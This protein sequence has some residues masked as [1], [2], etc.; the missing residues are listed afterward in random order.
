MVDASAA[1]NPAGERPALCRVPHRLAA[2]WHG[3]G[4]VA[5]S[6]MLDHPLASLREWIGPTT[7]GGGGCWSGGPSSFPGFSLRPQRRTRHRRSPRP[8]GCPGRRTVSPC[9]WAPFC[10]AS[11]RQVGPGWCSLG[12]GWCVGRPTWA[13]GFRAGC[14]QRGENDGTTNPVKSTGIGRPHDRRDL[15]LPGP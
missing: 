6:I 11:P 1:T 15:L 7:L 13:P 8:A 4:S 2:G 9:A 3:V 10:G 12:A 14:P 5:D